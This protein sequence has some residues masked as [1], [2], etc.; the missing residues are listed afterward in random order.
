[1]GATMTYDPQKHRRRSIRLKGYDY[2]QA[3]A[4]FVTICIQHGQSRLGTVQDGMLVPSPAGEMVAACWATLPERFPHIDLDVFTL[5]PNHIHGNILILK[6]G[7]NAAQNPIVLGDIVGAFKSI[8]THQYIQGVREK[9]WEPFQK[10]LWHRDYYEHIIRSE[11]ALDAIR[12]YI[13]HNPANWQADQ[14]HPQAPPNAFN[15][16]W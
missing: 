2:S 13:I 6:T 14:L 7:L 5:M 11:R 1:M 12:A 8:T 16:N 15:A 10:R 9:G 3:G 4:Y